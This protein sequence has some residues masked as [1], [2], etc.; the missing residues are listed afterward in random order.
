MAHLV[1]DQGIYRRTFTDPIIHL[2]CLQPR[3]WTKSRTCRT[4]RP[5]LTFS[6]PATT[7]HPCTHSKE[8]RNLG[9]STYPGGNTSPYQTAKPPNQEE[10]RA[11]GFIRFTALSSIPRGGAFFNLGDC[12]RGS[13][14]RVC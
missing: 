14:C 9:G 3:L 5:R 2:H 13:S 10:T 8:R 7:P 11:L 12:A 1:S 4:L 6:F